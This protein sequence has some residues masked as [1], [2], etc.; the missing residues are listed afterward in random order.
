LRA[1]SCICREGARHVP[2]TG[3]PIAGDVKRAPGAMTARA[4]RSILRERA[5]HFSVREVVARSSGD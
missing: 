3:S 1:A 2:G 4:P 5:P